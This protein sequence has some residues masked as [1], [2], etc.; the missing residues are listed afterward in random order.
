MILP[1]AL[2][3]MQQAD[4]PQLFQRLHLI[5]LRK[6]VRRNPQSPSDGAGTTTILRP[7]RGAKATA[8]RNG[9]RELTETEATRVARGS[10]PL[11]L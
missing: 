9:R 6:G 7:P 4:P 3:P 10:P 2:A 8:P 11:E 5:T 1:T